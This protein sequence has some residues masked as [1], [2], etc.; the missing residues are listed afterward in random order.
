M[1]E[2][3]QSTVHLEIAQ[4][5]VEK[6]ADGESHVSQEA[7]LQVLKPLLEGHIGPA[8][9]KLNK[10][11]EELFTKDRYFKNDL[12][13]KLSAYLQKIKFTEADSF[14]EEL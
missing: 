12:I 1:E 7:T 5:V 6:L 14:F 9:L 13:E 2:A 11:P 8:I 4:R 3:K 10:I